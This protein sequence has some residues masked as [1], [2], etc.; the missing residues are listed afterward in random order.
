VVV[1]DD[2]GGLEAAMVL[3]EGLDMMAV[4]PTERDRLIRLAAFSYLRQLEERHGD[5]VPIGPLRQGFEFE[6]Q[7]VPLMGPQGIFKPAALTEMPISI[8]TTP[9]VPGRPRPYED[10]V[11]SDGFLRYR[12][13]GRDPNHID[14]VGVGDDQRRA[15]QTS[16][17]E[18]AQEGKPTGSVFGGD[19]IHPEDLPM[20]IASG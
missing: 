5:V 19:H 20:P 4:D 13:R 11:A 10:E 7:R 8:T 18:A 16:G 2:A 6:G 15:R 3:V 14:H 9:P 1:A 17:D 12:Y